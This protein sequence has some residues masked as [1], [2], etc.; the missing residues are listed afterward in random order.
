MNHNWHF[1]QVGDIKRTYY[2]KLK[3][4]YLYNHQLIMFPHICYAPANNFN[5]EA[6]VKCNS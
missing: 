5:I 2:S 1:F 6:L 4:N 3:Q